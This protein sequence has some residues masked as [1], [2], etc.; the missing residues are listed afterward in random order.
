MPS[1]WR[2]AGKKQGEAMAARSG[3]CRILQLIQRD[4][5]ETVGRNK[6]SAS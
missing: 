4:Y 1:P 6:Q 5:G 2:V 3:S